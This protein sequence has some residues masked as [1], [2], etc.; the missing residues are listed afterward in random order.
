LLGL[1]H[2]ERNGHHYVFGMAGAPAA[3]QAAF[4]EA[5]RGLY[6]EV[7]GQT[8]LAIS[9]GVVD[10]AALSGIGYAAGVEPDWRA[11]RTMP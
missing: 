10:I 3:E 6:R 11:M 5:H 1:A 7:L 2:V 9:D 8:C 4:R